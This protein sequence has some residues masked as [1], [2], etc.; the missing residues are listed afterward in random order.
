MPL[1]PEKYKGE[2]VEV[3]FLDHVS[4]SDAEQE[5]VICTIWGRLIRDDW[6]EIQIR[7]W[8]TDAGESSEDAEF[9][10]LIRAGVVSIRPL[11]FGDGNG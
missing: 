3:R 8:E 11:I 10:V 9:V 2:I 4:S 6:Q 1:Q 7:T 5:L